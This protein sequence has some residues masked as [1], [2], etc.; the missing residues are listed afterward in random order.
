MQ[1]AALPDLLQLSC[2]TT[3]AF[4][5][6][7]HPGKVFTILQNNDSDTLKRLCYIVLYRLEEKAMA[8]TEI[9][10]CKKIYIGKY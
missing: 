4:N 8:I 6:S 1:P 3:V 9:A 10:D 5:L 7:I 2:P